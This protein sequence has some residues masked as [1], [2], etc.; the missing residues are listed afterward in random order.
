MLMYGKANNGA[1][2]CTPNLHYSRGQ[3]DRSFDRPRLLSSFI[4]FLL[5]KQIKS[6]LITK[7]LLECFLT[8]FN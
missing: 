4:Y 1:K 5:N 8:L 7:C 2:W 3:L 6:I